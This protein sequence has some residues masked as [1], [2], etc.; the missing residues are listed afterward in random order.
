MITEQERG[1]RV[2]CEAV[3]FMCTFTHNMPFQE[4]F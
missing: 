3:Q 2:V 1:F 4:F